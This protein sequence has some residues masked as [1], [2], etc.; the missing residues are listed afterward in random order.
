MMT[1]YI[2]DEM[3]DEIQKE[4]MNDR[5][6]S[7]IFFIL[8]RKRK[9]ND[10]SNAKTVSKAGLNAGLDDMLVTLA[11]LLQNTWQKQL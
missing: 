6:C 4:N 5:K 7:Y 3:Q 10:F 9:W 2:L 1:K 11:F 8:Q